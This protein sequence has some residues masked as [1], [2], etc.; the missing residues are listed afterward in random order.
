MS[1]LLCKCHAFFKANTMLTIRAASVDATQ[2]RQQ[3]FLSAYWLWGSGNSL[4]MWMNL[5]LKIQNTPL[6]TAVTIESR[7]LGLLVVKCF[8]QTPKLVGAARVFAAGRLAVQC[9]SWPVLNNGSCRHRD[10]VWL[11][12]PPWWRWHGSLSGFLFSSNFI[13]G[14]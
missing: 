4:P 3:K 13:R 12:P 8:T 1:A 7:R 14:L 2:Q 10:W 6:G 9:P 5:L 11:L